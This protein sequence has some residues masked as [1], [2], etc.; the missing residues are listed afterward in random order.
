MG[1]S[2][3]K[4][5]KSCNCFSCASFWIWQVN[6]AP[7]VFRD[8]WCWDMPL[9]CSFQPFFTI[10]LQKNTLYDDYILIGHMYPKFTLPKSNNRA[11]T[12]HI[13]NKD[14]VANKKPISIYSFKIEDLRL[15]FCF[16]MLDVALFTTWQEV[17]LN[18]WMV[19][20]EVGWPVIFLLRVKSV[21]T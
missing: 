6:K 15:W 4:S 5:F 18:N 21:I 20:S 12:F 14:Y 11:L 9:V 7:V 2:A 17:M 10:Y 1:L 3:L 19:Q 16:N 8:F 13:V